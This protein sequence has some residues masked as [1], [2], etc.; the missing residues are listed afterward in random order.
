VSHDIIEKIVGVIK[1]QFKLQCLSHRNNS[2]NLEED[3][4]ARSSQLGFY[5]VDDIKIII[6]EL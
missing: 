2:E 5:T 4:S 6:V 1:P 3:L